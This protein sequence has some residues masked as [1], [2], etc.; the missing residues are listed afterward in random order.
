MGSTTSMT[1]TTTAVIITDAAG[2]MS[3]ILNGD[4]LYWQISFYDLSSDAI[5]VTLNRHGDP[6][7][8]LG[9]NSNQP[10]LPIKSP[11]IGG[12]NLSQRLIDKLLGG[13][14]TLNIGTTLA[15]KGELVT[16]ICRGDV[17]KLSKDK[18]ERSCKH[19]HRHH[20]E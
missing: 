14:L 8:D 12:G 10:T 5:S 3:L 20:S 4:D 1:P 16:V 9:S 6:V 7:F 2:I 13:K 18:C 17:F 11:V 19:R 15:P